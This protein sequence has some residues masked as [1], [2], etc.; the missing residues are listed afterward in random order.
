MK[1]YIIMVQT[2]AEKRTLLRMRL[3]EKKIQ[4]ENKTLLF[5][6]W[7]KSCQSFHL[8]WTVHCTGHMLLALK[9][10]FVLQFWRIAVQIQG[11]CKALLPQNLISGSLCRVWWSAGYLCH[12]LTN[13]T[14]VSAF[15]VMWHSP[16]CVCL[17]LKK[18]HLLCPF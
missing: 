11:V 7:G 2:N 1:I 14:T 6:R 18:S 4:S 17:H 16:L 8:R 15:A 12:S 13:R 5:Q 10:H 3:E 9:Q